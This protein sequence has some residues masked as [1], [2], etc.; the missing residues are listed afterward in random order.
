MGPCFKSYKSYKFDDR[1]ETILDQAKM[2]LAGRRVWRL[3]G[4][5]LGPGSRALLGQFRIISIPYHTTDS[6][7]ESEGKGGGKGFKQEIWRHGGILTIGIP[8]AWGVYM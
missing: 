2:N 6:F 8:K 3:S 1:P 7:S 4:N 5:Y